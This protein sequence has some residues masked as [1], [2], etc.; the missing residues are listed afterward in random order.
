[1]ETK[2]KT[3][4]L[5][6]TLFVMFFGVAVW[7]IATAVWE[8]RMWNNL[9]FDE[10]VNQLATS[11]EGTGAGMIRDYLRCCVVPGVLALA[12]ALCVVV[13][14]LRRRDWGKGFRVGAA[15]SGAVTLGML[16]YAFVMLDVGGYLLAS[17]QSSDYI[18]EH[19]V[20]P[21]Q[22]QLTFPEKKKN[23]VYIWLE[24]MEST[25]AEE[26]QGGEFP[27]CP[28]PELV[29]LGE[30]NLSFTGDRG[31]VNGGYVPVGTTWT[32][33]ALFAQTTGLPLKIPIDANA[34]DTQKN[35]FPGITALGDILAE[36]GYQ[37]GFLIGSDAT[38]GGRRNF[39][40]QH[41]DY[42]IWDYP[43][44][45]ETGQLPQDYGVFWGYEDEK[46][47]AFA[48]EHLTEMAATGQPFNLSLLTV[49]THFPDGYVCQNCR[50]E[51]GADQYSNVM[52]CSSRQVAEF[53]AWI[54]AQP[55]YEDTVI[56]LS[57][58]HV[59][60]DADYCKDIP[61]DYTRRVYTTII[62][63]DTPVADPTRYRS[64]TTLDN[65]P[66]TLAALG[67]TIQGNRLGL[68][69]NLFS[70]EDTLLEQTSFEELNRQLRAQSD[71]MAE[72]SGLSKALYQLPETFAGVDTNPQ[73]TFR[74]DEITF[75][76][77]GLEEIEQDFTKVELFV[78]VERGG[79]RT[80]AWYEEA[81]KQPDGSYTVTMP[82]EALEG[83]ET[84]LLLVNATTESGRIQVDSEYR[85]DRTAQTVAR[86]T[87]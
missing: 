2:Q 84:F 6:G 64:Y 23:L 82:V 36:N 66:T 68:G 22:V 61:R 12:A 52:A 43:Y 65:F 69:V 32:A 60:M 13:F 53:V 70:S 11:M 40:T 75:A 72:K 48:K 15:L 10:I 17:N 3:H 86:Q 59:T 9:T 73:V 27:R 67:V 63:S 71:F 80:T 62:N 35:F 4:W 33:G 1:M 8:A 39:F 34:M 74:E 31:G 57:G 26:D 19:Y 76:V 18:Q 54:Q 56:I 45:L 20:D 50:E 30:E 25:F 7:L 77:S 49:D 14:G 42:E 5:A 44:S 38:F 47:F 85:C 55:F 41:G 51:F 81:K 24:S 46:L 58:D 21:D 78:D 83:S 28:I 37:Q 29:A 16:V 87:G 79:N